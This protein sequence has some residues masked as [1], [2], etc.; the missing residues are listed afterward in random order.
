MFHTALR[1]GLTSPSLS[2]STRQN[3][4]P[5]HFAADKGHANV[6]ALLLDRGASL[7][8][9]DLR[10]RLWVVS[11]LVM[12]NRELPVCPIGFLCNDHQKF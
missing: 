4:T 9:P 1:H 5:L 11:F 10:V 8:V 7:E 2:R 6:C 12:L 3:R